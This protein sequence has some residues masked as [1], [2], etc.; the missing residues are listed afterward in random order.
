MIFSKDNTYYLSKRLPLVSLSTWY[1][2]YNHNYSFAKVCFSLFQTT[3][4]RYSNKLVESSDQSPGS[5]LFGTQLVYVDYHK[6]L[7]Y[8][9]I[10]TFMK[11]YSFVVFFS[12]FLHDNGRMKQLLC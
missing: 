11:H 12:F 4:V 3:H 2:R 10:L 8:F 1:V 7:F 9:I 5:F 6:T